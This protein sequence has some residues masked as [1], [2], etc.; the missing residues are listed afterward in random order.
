MDAVSLVALIISVIALIGA[1]LQLLQQ[2]YS[3]AAGYANCGPRVMGPWAAT[4]RRKFRWAELRFEVQFEAPVLFVCP[5]TNRRGPVRHQPLWFVKGT[6][7]SEEQTR[8]P[9]VET[10]KAAADQKEE[11][12]LQKKRHRNRDVHTAD[13]E[14]ANWFILLQAF[15]KM[16]RES[17]A[18]AQASSKQEA[19]ALGP[20]LAGDLPGGIAPSARGHSTVLAL[21]PSRRS[22]DA[23]P[24]GIRRPYATSTIC[25]VVEMAALLGLHWRTFD[26]AAHRYHAEGNGY[27]LTGREVVGLGGTLFRFQVY[28]KNRFARSRVVPSDDVK[29]LCFGHVP[30]IFGGDAAKAGYDNEDDGDDP[31]SAGIVQLGSTGELIESLAHFGCNSKTTNYFRDDSKYRLGHLFP[32]K[33]ISYLLMARQEL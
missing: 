16:E 33:F 23:M 12:Q 13:N 27:L 11:D 26:R 25:H 29:R 8:V 19:G 7:K 20:K 28:G 9:S 18:W 22:W 31:K 6:R 5:P 14:R 32:S 24:A 1:I 15:H 21:Q 2:Y 3:S 30:T 10:E 4:R 17:H